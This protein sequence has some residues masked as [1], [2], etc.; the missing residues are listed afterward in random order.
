MNYEKKLFVNYSGRFDPY[1][2]PNRIFGMSIGM[3]KSNLN[4]KFLNTSLK[5]FK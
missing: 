1:L 3:G 2:C 4:L 5:L